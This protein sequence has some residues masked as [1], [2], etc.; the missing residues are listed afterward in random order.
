MAF[1]CDL[2]ENNRLVDSLIPHITIATALN[3]KPA[4]SANVI[5]N[6]LQHKIYPVNGNFS[7]KI[8]LFY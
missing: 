6:K 2:G 1:E 8:T 5:A 7:G 4:E 3:I